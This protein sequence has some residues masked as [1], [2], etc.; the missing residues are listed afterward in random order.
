MANRP[1]KNQKRT[2]WNRKCREKLAANIHSRLGITVEPSQ[3]RLKTNDDDPYTWEKTEAI[4]HLFTQNLSEF[5]IKSLQK[6]CE[7]IDDNCVAATWKPSGKAPR[8]TLRGNMQGH[9]VK[10]DVSFT[11]RIIELEKTEESLACELNEWKAQASLESEGRQKAEEEAT[12]M[13][14]ALREAREDGRKLEEYIQKWKTEA[15]K[16]SDNAAKSREVIDAILALLK[17]FGSSIQEESFGLK[18][19]PRT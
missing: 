8:T 7:C 9:F 3:V 16:S 2:Q 12:R 11:A 15:K 14:I 6:L 4:S 19:S 13:E 18:P 17:D 10:S 1:S 5:S